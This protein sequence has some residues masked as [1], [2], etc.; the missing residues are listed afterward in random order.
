MK[1]VIAAASVDDVG[2]IGPFQHVI[3]RSTDD[4]GHVPEA[5]EGV[6]AGVPEELFGGDGYAG[7]HGRGNG[8]DG[9]GVDM[10]DAAGDDEGQEE[11]RSYETQRV[12]GSFIGHFLNLET[13]S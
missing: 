7:R 1:G 12:F 4:G 6:L 8:F 5:P 9:D 2:A 3:A 10:G 13:M 11:E